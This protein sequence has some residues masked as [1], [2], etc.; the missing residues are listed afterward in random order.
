MKVFGEN[1]LQNALNRCAY[2]R[3]GMQIIQYNGLEQNPLESRYMTHFFGPTL[4]NS[5]QSIRR[6]IIVQ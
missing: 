6:E 3:A 2:R 5:Q 4:L 1:I